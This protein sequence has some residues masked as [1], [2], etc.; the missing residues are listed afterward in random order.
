MAP[1]TTTNAPAGPTP[2]L[3]SLTSLNPLHGRV[4]AIHESSFFHLFSEEK[5]LGLARALAGLLLPEPGSIIFGLHL[6][7]TEKGSVPEQNYS[8]FCHSPATWAEL[9]DGLVFEKGM[10]KVKTMLV[11][12]ER[13]G[14]EVDEANAR[15]VTLLVWSVTRL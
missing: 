11:Q 12:V 3:G 10:V 5:Q 14:F 4:A 15:P 13:K 8:L 6:G 7:H 9:W 1:F 2:E